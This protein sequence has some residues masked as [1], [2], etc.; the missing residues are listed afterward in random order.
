MGPC[1]ANARRPTVDRADVVALRSVAVWCST[2]PVRQFVARVRLH[3]WSHCIAGGAEE[4][5]SCDVYVWCRCNGWTES[6]YSI[7]DCAAAAAASHA[8]RNH[9]CHDQQVSVE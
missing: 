4:V 1:T 6:D 5:W 7:N 2:A 8:C 9:S 3:G